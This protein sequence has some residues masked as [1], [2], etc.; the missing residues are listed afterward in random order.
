MKKWEGEE[1]GDGADGRR[2]RG[3]ARVQQGVR[4]ARREQ[5][6]GRRRPGEGQGR[7]R[8]GP[9]GGQEGMVDFLLKGT[10]F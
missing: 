5:G 7:A 1:E 4:R 3:P 2:R 6:G 10:C 8:S 9:G